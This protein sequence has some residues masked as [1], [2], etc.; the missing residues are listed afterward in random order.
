[1]SYETLDVRINCFMEIKKLYFEC[2][3]DKYFLI[4]FNA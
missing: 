4:L 2:C 1:M 3:V